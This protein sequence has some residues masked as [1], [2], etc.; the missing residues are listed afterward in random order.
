MIRE[1]PATNFYIGNFYAESLILA[2]TGNVAGSIQIAGTDEII[3][4]PFFVAALRL[5]PDR[6]GALRGERVSVARTAAARAR[7]RGRTGAR[8]PW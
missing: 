8:R 2:E 3:Q 1:K 7:S 4:I 5:H 6:R